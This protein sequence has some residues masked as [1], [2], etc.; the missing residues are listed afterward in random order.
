MLILVSKNALKSFLMIDWFPVLLKAN[1]G[2]AN[3]RT[4]QAIKGFESD[5]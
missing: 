2:W 4:L 3:F 5:Y 1:T